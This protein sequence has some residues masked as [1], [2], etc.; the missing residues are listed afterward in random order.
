[1]QQKRMLILE[2]KPVGRSLTARNLCGLQTV[3][4]VRVTRKARQRLLAGPSG[5]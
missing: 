4:P 1:M 3:A 5:P 2:P